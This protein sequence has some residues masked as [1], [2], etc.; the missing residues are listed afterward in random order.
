MIRL[1]R[2][3]RVFTRLSKGSGTKTFKDLDRTANPSSYDS[4]SGHSQSI[5]LALC[6]LS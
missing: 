1:R 6:F 3:P 4:T 5:L 2:G